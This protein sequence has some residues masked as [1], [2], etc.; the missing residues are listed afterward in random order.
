MD[1]DYMLHYGLSMAGRNKAVLGQEKFGHRVQSL[2]GP[3]EHPIDIGT[4]NETREV[5]TTIA[6]RIA[7]RR[8]T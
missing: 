3:R 5:S 2:S 1:M 4:A 8:H 6:Q 7:S